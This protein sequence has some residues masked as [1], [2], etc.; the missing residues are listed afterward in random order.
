MKKTVILNVVGL[1]PSLLGKNTPFLSAWAAIGQVV[2]IKTVLPAV[3]CS[4][5]ATYLTG[6]LPDEHGIVAN[7]W[8]FR[9]ECEV[10]FWRQSNKLVQAPK[11]WDIAKSIDPN[12]TCANLFWWYNMYSSVDY[13][14]TPRPMYPA[15]GRK[16]PDIYTHPSDVRSPIQSDLGQF[17]LFDFWGPKT[18]IN[19]SQ[20][21]ADSAKWIEERYSPT[22]SLVYLPH[23]DYCL[24]KFGHDE[25]HI[26]ADLQ[27]IDA[28][29]GDLIEYYQ[30]RNTQIIILSEYGITPVNKAVDLNRVLRENN[31]IAVR[32]EL[33]R[34]LL[35]FGASIAFAVAD[36]QI[37]HVYVND[38]AYIPKVRSLLEATEGVAQVLDE[39]GKQAY[40][41]N[42]PRSGELVAIASPDTWFTYYYWL[43]DNKAPD[44]ARTVDIH[45]KP[46]YDPVELFLDPQIKFPQ[47]KIA[48][49][50]LKKQLGFRYLMD[51]IPVDASL[52]RGSHGHITTSVD[53][54]PLFI[55]HQTHLVDTNLIEATDVCSLI[56]KHLST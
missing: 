44:F 40:H 10:K 31:L 29:C 47:G 24:Q 6:K 3:T 9:D 27:E 54:G 39:Q 12:F 7:G 32:E 49:K 14:I 38:P 37:A 51:V 53:E 48:L 46:G 2:P 42:H 1:T 34:E 30:A 11:V 45:R 36:H 41:L 8:Y 4:V 22:L 50:L 55:T 52:V 25:K 5:Q 18:S 17:P 43:D 33:G 15:D 23:L 35:D 28:V 19:S 20:W 16:L 56:L 26:Q 21:I 13:A